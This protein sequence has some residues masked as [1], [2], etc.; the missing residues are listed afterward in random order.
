MLQKLSL[1]LID[2]ELGIHDSAPEGQEVILDKVPEVQDAAMHVAEQLNQL[3][4]AFA[5]RVCDGIRTRRNSTGIYAHAMAAVMSAKDDDLSV[6]LAARVIYERA[7]DRQPRIQFG[8]LKTVLMHFQ[9]LQ[10]DEDGR[11]LV[12]AYDPQDEKVSVVD[13]QL[14]LYRKFAT[15]KW[16]WEDLIEEVSKEQSAFD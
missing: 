5:K 13:K 12:V 6:G 11:G 14:L 2:D 4:Q 10:V 16:P 8:N 15:V 3:Y 7:H 9:E 1:R